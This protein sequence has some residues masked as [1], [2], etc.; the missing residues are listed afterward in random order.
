MRMKDL[1]DKL[2]S[3][4]SVVQLEQIAIQQYDIPAYELMKRAGKAIFHV[5]QKKY[6]QHKNILV[7][8]G[9]GNNAGD[10]YV[11]ARLAKQAG[12]STRVISLMDVDSLRGTALLAYQDWSGTGRNEAVDEAFIEEADLIV[13]ALLGTG[14]K[15]DVSGDWAQWIDRVNHS[16]KPVIAVDVPSGLIADT[17]RIA[18]HAIQATITVSFIGLKQGMFTAHARDVCGQILFDD[19]GLPAGLYSRVKSDARLIRQADY[20]LLPRRK[21]S[22]HKGCFGHVL[23]VGGNKTM[24]G[25]VILAARAAL[26]SGA[27]LLTIITVAEN[28]SAISSAVPEAM[29][30]TCELNSVREV[31][32]GKITTGVTHVA[33]GMGLAQDDWSLAVLKRCVALKKPMLIDADALSLMARHELNL[34]STTV[35]T[36]HPGEAA[37]LLSESGDISSADVQKDRFEAVKRLYRLLN[38]NEPGT[39]VLKGS[40]TLIFDGQTIKICTL[41]NAAMAAPGMGDVL[42]GITIALMAQIAEIN[43][44]VE[45]AVCL[46]SAA[47]DSVVSGNTRGLLASDVIEALPGMLP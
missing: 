20:S 16:G 22:S 1:P 15:R 25:A 47:A 3:V 46:H 24:P 34:E 36:P 38:N 27:G 26:R 32:S 2:Y 21:A 5:I 37:R 39:V 11:L 13:D 17:G 8:C 40:G 10:G 41:G 18:G 14:L 6:S 33:V 43:D 19:L 12:F 23:I 44:A 7:L 29:I 45:L 42:S 4:K 30:M 9:A 35:I 28:L 31:F